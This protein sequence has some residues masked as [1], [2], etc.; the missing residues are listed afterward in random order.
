MGKNTYTQMFDQELAMKM[1]GVGDRSIAE[2]IYRS[3][4]K[5]LERQKGIENSEKIKIDKLLPTRK[6]LKVSMENS[7]AINHRRAKATSSQ[8]ETLFPQYRSIIREAAE[9]YNLNPLLINSIIKAESNGDPRAVSPVGAKG[10]MQLIDTTAADMGVNDV[11]DPEQN[12]NA[13]ARYLRRM[14]DRFGDLKKAL[15]A[16]NAGPETVKRYGGVPPYPETRAYV[17]QVLK[18]SAVSQRFTK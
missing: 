13:G 2:S 1:S 9:K 14:I 4:E 12:I 18:H 7:S 17:K 3:M 11:F 5:V 10:L 6:Y 16:Y 8:E 15:A